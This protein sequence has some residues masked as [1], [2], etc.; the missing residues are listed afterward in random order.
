[1]SSCGGIRGGLWLSYSRVIG[2]LPS[3]VAE[4]TKAPG[5]RTIREFAREQRLS[6][7]HDA[8]QHIAMSMMQA[9]AKEHKH[10]TPP[11]RFPNQPP[12][13]PLTD[14]KPFAEAP[15]VL[16][17]FKEIRAGIDTKQ[18]TWEEFELTSGEYDQ[19]KSALHQD[20]ALSGYV[21]DKIRLVDF[22]QCENNG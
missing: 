9:N 11:P 13:P 8:A 2:S 3:V 5:F 14:K 22:R 16:K 12:T 4:S 21:Q 19:I 17:L 1:V 7:H 15:R 20:N 10:V 6:N 18:R